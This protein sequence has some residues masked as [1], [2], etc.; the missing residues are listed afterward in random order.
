VF[1]MDGR[2]VSVVL[3]LDW[4]VALTESGE[5]HQDRSGGR[6]KEGGAWGGAGED[7]EDEALGV[8]KRA[9]G[10][11]EGKRTRAKQEAQRRKPKR[12]PPKMTFVQKP[13]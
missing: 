8:K 1:E 7:G 6:M 12:N 5:R 3:A 10:M 9:R 2:L 4:R 13:F 11:T